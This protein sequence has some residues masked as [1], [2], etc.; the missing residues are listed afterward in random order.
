LKK[1]REKKIKERI[2]NLN[3]LQKDISEAKKL[4]D[5]K[6]KKNKKYLQDTEVY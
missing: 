5:D 2:K 4:F 1:E 6:L 3:K